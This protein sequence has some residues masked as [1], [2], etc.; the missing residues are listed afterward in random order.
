MVRSP[1][2]WSYLAALLVAGML[3]FAAGVPVQSAETKTLEGT[4]SDTMCGAKHMETNVT[5]AECTVKCVAMGSK[6]AL[7][8][9][10][11]VYELN[12]KADDLKKLAGA[13]AKITGSVDGNKVQVTG[14]SKI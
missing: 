10:D 9:G 7:V 6:Y 12:G 11:N 5:P 2:K 4:I 13:K 3:L 1:N 8:V 14:V